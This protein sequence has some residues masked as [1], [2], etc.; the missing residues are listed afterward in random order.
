VANTE[1]QESVTEEETLSQLLNVSLT[2]AQFVLEIGKPGP[3]LRMHIAGHA[4]TETRVRTFVAPVTVVNQVTT[5]VTTE[6]F[7]ERALLETLL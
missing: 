3:R 7:R 6:Q 4:K 5:A 1:L 2:P